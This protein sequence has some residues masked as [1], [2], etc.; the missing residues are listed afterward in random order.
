MSLPLNAPP[1]LL[2]SMALRYDHALGCPGYYDQEFLAQPGVTHEMRLKST[3][4]IMQ[5]LYEEVAGFGFYK[6]ELEQKYA[7]LSSGQSRRRFEQE[8]P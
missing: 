7:I 6:P 4:N 5:Q 1:G 2:M 3:L 8:N